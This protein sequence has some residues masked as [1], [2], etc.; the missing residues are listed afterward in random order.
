MLR[1]DGIEHEP[2]ADP[3]WQPEVSVV[4]PL[5]DHRGAA[6][7]CVQSFVR[8][9]TYPRGRF[10]MIVLSDGSDPA[11]DDRVKALLGP[12][13]QIVTHRTT[14]LYLL[15]HLGALEA[16]GK[17][18]FITE[19]H[20]IAEPT[21]LEELTTFF[22][23]RDYDGACCSST[24]ICV[25]AWARVER[26]YSDA[27]FQVFSQPGHWRK[28]FWKGFAIHRDVYL[29]E[30]GLEPQFSRFSE[31]VLGAKLHS[32]GRR[33]GYATRATVRH[34]NLTSPFRLFP[35][36]RAFSRGECTYRAAAPAEYC[37]RYF[38]YVEEWT[39]REAFRPVLAR[40]L[41]RAVLWSLVG[42]MAR[43]RRW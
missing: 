16:K 37:E 10:E 19:P 9:Q 32:R 30:G 28:V 39:Q 5:P 22:D 15:Y 17:L 3:P 8:D 4:V 7:E 20:C 42:E 13:D 41:C 29:E 40:V 12:Q 18:I 23:T 21:C 34:K 38:G 25:N 2:R 24:G 26:R 35:F 33:L 36:I 43:N 31:C 6:L 14:N 1:A 27:T 11:L